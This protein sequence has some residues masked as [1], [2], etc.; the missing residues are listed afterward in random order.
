MWAYCCKIRTAERTNQN[1]L[2]IADQLSRVISVHIL[3]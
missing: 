2:F 1:L 3:I